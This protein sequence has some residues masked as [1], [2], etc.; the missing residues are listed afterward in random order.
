MDFLALLE[1]GSLYISGVEH[2]QGT[3]LY[4]KAY[5]DLSLKSL[6]V[7]VGS[8]GPCTWEPGRGVPGCCGGLRPLVVF[9]FLF[10]S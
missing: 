2:R 6:F 5:Q 1:Y 9:L 10:G 7:V 4:V 8:F 3:S